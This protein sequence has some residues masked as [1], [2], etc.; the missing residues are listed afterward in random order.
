VT[1]QKE[2]RHIKA[3]RYGEAMLPRTKLYSFHICTFTV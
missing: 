2:A 3:F 1:L